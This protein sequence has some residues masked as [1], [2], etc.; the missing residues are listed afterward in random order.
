[1]VKIKFCYVIFSLSYILSVI[2]VFGALSV[3]L[4]L[5]AVVC[6]ESQQVPQHTV[7]DTLS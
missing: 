2:Y 4:F 5:A 7:F 6:D 3:N 1:M